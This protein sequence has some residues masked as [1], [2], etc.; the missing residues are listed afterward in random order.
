MKTIFISFAFILL[1]NCSQ[2]TI[3]R[4]GYLGAP[5]PNID[6]SYNDIQAA[7]N[8]ANPGDTLQ[9]YQQLA[10]ASTYLLDI[11]KPLKIIG[12]GHTLNINTGNQV[13]NAADGPNNYIQNLRFFQ[14]SAGSVV[15]GLNIWSC[16]VNDSNITVTRCRFKG[17][18]PTST[19]NAC[20]T[21]APFL[22]PTDGGGITVTANNY[23][24]KNITI[25]GCYFDQ[26]VNIA[27]I[28]NCYGTYVTT[29]LLVTNNYFNGPVNLTTGITG[30]VYG[31]FANNIMNHKFQ[32]LFDTYYLNA[33]VCTQGVI[34]GA[35]LPYIQSNF[36]Y[37]L[38]K[39]NIINTDDTVKC[40]FNAPHSIIQNN[41]FSMA[42]Q[43]ACPSLSSSNNIYKANM[44]T[45][46]GALW[47]NGMVYNDNQLALGVSSAAINAG[48]KENLTTTNCGIYG[49]ETGQQY[50]LSG[51]PSVPSIYLL[52]TPS[53]YATTNPFN[54]TV[55]VKSNN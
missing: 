35:W 3:R 50:R 48:I 41:I 24:L 32:H 14:G 11:Y 36:D 15:Q 43:Y 4:V 13:Q 25:N 54:I 34:G 8:T 27:N 16:L 39:N 45:V 18:Y 49:G 47:N 23:N 7:A 12:F 55:S 21:A 2:A 51:I 46:F 17:N 53:I 44:S 22:Y 29:N 26:G 19:F 20:G 9:I 10:I 6:F 31:V 38:I 1:A 33:N 28:I 40:T 52:T 42:S 5:V 37:F 30:Q